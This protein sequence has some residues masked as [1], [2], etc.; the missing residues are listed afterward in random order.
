M[1][2][3]TKEEIE[4]TKCGRF[5]LSDENIYLSIYSLNSY[6]FEYNL[7][8]TEDRILYHR[9]QDKF[10]ARLI[11][12]VITR[13]R[14]QIIELFD[15]DKYIE[16][17]V[18]FKPKKLSE[19]G[20]LEFRPLHSTGLITQIAIVSMLHLFVYEIPEEEEGD[21][22]LRL[23]NLSRLIP[24]DFY[25]N[26]VSVKPE[27][28][29]KPW[30]QQYQK[31]NQN[32]NDALMKYHTSLEY[33]YEV[34]LDLEN[35][36]PTINPIII[37]RYII[38]HLPAYLN[39]EER[40][41]MKRV[42][43]KL[44][45]CK[46][47]TTFDEKTAGQYYKVTK[48]AGNYDNVDKIE[49]N[50]KECW[51]F[52]EKSDKFVRGIPQGL[53]QSYFL[54][55]IYMISIAEIFRKKFTGVSYFY[56]DD[57]VIFTNDVREDN[58]KEQLKELN[59]QI[60][61]EANQ[62]YTEKYG[63]LTEKAVRENLLEISYGETPFTS[64]YTGKLS[65]DDLLMFASKLIKRYPVLLKK[66]GDKYNYI[67]IDEYQD[68]SSYV[69]DIFYD[70]VKNRE[71]V[72]I[73]L[74]GDR[75]QQIYRNYDGSF[76]GK[77]K[78][79]DTSDRL[80]VNFRSIGKI[81]SILNNIYN[82]SSFEQ[83]PT[84]SNA[85][86]VPDI[87]PHVIIS[88]NVPESIYKLQNKFPK[89]LVL[90]LM[91]KE[92]YEEIGAK[93]LYDAYRGMEA[94]TFGRKYSPTDILSDMSNDNPDILM[95]FLFLLNNVIGLYIDK[96]YGMVISICKKEN[97]YFDSSQFK[98]K[99]HADKKSIKNKFDKIIEIYEKD[100]CLIREVIESLFDNGFIPEKVKNDF[101]ENIEYQKV[102]DI[103]MKEVSNLAN[104]LSMPHISTQHGVKGESHT[105]V[106]FVASDNGNTP[107]VR[108]YPFFE[109]WSE[110]EFSL[111]QFEELFYSYKKIIEEVEKE[112]G[113]KV[114]RCNYRRTAMSG[115]F[116]S[117]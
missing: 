94:Y 58:F 95:K 79:F 41:M 40:K 71:N 51:A 89:I 84:E 74:F 105:S 11:N 57:S 39:D 98:I 22:K 20:E 59:K 101:E 26:R 99:K 52:K 38:N 73:Y 54:G 43:Q 92:K 33:K 88:S 100:G 50:E 15:K 107:N 90:Y 35:F 64:L 19:N 80:E 87:E 104:Y 76:E 61:D 96:N 16:A 7:L 72:Q 31:Y 62:Y 77:L 5:L 37:Y 81:V 14:E 65:H 47:T 102:L 44:L 85:N 97:K 75:M 91:N 117:W 67:F 4:K 36:F 63:K 110:L 21:P 112:L 6:V 115:L 68:T 3:I 45:F 34:T 30:K 113:M 28:L 9:L 29:F 69:L 109:L 66:I 23:S 70:A 49:Q 18:Y 25:G 56:V 78:E 8:N 10:D 46:L 24:S 111:P 53:P 82:D 55:N 1:S 48:G 114:S 106:I 60:A 93:N 17:K 42:L 27:Y 103:E 13:V 83:Q 116:G 108:M 2:R 12:G 86:V 32:S